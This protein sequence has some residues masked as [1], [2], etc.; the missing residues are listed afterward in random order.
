MN[1]PRSLLIRLLRFLGKVQ[2]TTVLLL[3][4]VVI[5]TIGTILE[6]R[7]SREIAWSAVYSIWSSR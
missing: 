7:G 6:S 4:G 5:M 2:F 3:A 1:A